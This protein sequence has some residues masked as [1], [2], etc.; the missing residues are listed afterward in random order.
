MQFWMNGSFDLAFYGRD[1]HGDG[2]SVGVRCDLDLKLELELAGL[3][4]LQMDRRYPG[5]T[6]SR[7]R[8]S[9]PRAERRVRAMNGGDSETGGIR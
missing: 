1:F 4:R 7:A 2:L 9:G 6:G 3:S 8:W 5:L